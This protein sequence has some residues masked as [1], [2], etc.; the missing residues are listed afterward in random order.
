LSRF[1]ILFTKVRKEKYNVSMAQL[2]LTLKLPFLRLNHCKAVEFEELTRLNTEVANNIVALPKDVRKQL[3]SKDFVGVE[4]GSGWINQTIRNANAKTKVKQFKRIPLEVNNQGWKIHKVGETYSLIFN[5]KRG[6][7]KRLPLEVHQAQHA[8][9]LSKLLDGQA[10]QG[11][12]KLWRSFKGVWYAMLSVSMEVPD[13]EPVSGWIGVDRG[14]NNIAVAS[15]PSGQPKFF[16]AG[17]VGFIR[18]RY[19]KL[20]KALGE[21]KRTKTIQ[22]IES[23]ER[24]IVTHINHII[25]KELVQFAKHYGFGLCF[26]DLSGIRQTSKQRKKTKSKADK[27]RDFWPFYQ[28]EQFTLYKAIRAGVPTRNRPAPYTSKSCCKCGVLGNRNH[29]RFVCVNPHCGAKYHA[30]WGASQTIGKW[31]GFACSLELKEGALV[32]SSPV[33]GNGVYDSPPNSVSE[34]FPA[35]AG[36]L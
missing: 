14:Q 25:S 6:R 15:L 26:E 18:K 19:A 29:H 22:K 24:R 1:N 5:P 28:L 16:K 7:S 31:D 12:L 33:L 11:S 20:R 34:Q 8:Q 9:T 30:D 27:N 3:T 13:T 36:E 23:R 2:T 32:M 17:I 35:L 10:K 21:T 4:I